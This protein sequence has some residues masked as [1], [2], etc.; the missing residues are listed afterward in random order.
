M[1]KILIPLFS[2]WSTESL[3]SALLLAF[4]LWLAIYWVLKGWLYLWNRS[5]VSTHRF[6]LH[7]IILIGMAL[8]ASALWVN[9]QTAS[10]ILHN[11]QLLAN[12]IPPLKAGDLDLILRKAP[13][14][15]PEQA[16]ASLIY[17][18]LCKRALSDSLFTCDL[19]NITPP[20]QLA[21]ELSALYSNRSSAQAV[22]SIFNTIRQPLNSAIRAD[23]SKAIYE[24]NKADLRD[25]E[26][27][28]D[29]VAVRSA[30]LLWLLF[31][32]VC[33]AYQGYMGIRRISPTV[34]GIKL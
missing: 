32:A 27:L 15:L 19:L 28:P 12:Q 11:S 9:S 7:F 26:S 18:E 25:W 3:V 34:I 30:A 14:A 24:K 17:S 4:I 29:M 21:A 6:L 13:P 10:T 23:L 5:W 22:N 20:A 8:P 2:Y 1:Q 33:F 16:A 31:W